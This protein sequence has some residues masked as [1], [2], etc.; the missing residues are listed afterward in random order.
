MKGKYSHSTN[1]FL[2]CLAAIA[3]LAGILPSAQA[4][5]QPHGNS[6]Q[7]SGYAGTDLLDR[8]PFNRVERSNFWTGGWNI[9][10]LRT[11]SVTVSYAEIH[12][13]FTS[14]DFRDTYQARSSWS[15]GAEAH[16]ITHLRKFSMSG[17]F[18]FDNFSGKEMCGQM[19]ARPGYY[20]FDV[21]EFTPGPKIMQTYAFSG[22]ITADIAPH[23]R[24]GGM[25]SYTGANYTKRK[26]LR[27]SNY[28][29]DMTVSPSVLYHSGDFSMGLSYIFGKN[30]ETIN[31]DELGISSASYYAFL[32]KGLMFGAYETWEGS[33]IHLSESGVNG[34][35]AR[36][37]R[38]GVAIQAGWRNFYGEASYVFGSGS[39]GEK[40]SIWF[41]FPSHSAR[42]TAGYSFGKKE[43]R[44]LVRLAVSWKGLEN[45]ENV[46]GQETVN[47]V[48]ITKVYGSNLI[49]E[50]SVVNI[51]PSYEWLSGKASIKAGADIRWQARLSSQMYP[52]LFSRDDMI[53]RVYASGSVSL[54]MFDLKAGLAFSYGN[55]LEKDRVVDDGIQ[56]GE[57]PYHLEDLYEMQNEY[58]T[59]PRLESALGLRYNFLKGLY[60]EISGGYARGFNIAVLDGKDRWSGNIR[61]GYTF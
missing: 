37:L 42:L 45:H 53:S 58:M 14:G 20:P 11:D 54:K 21:L 33:G 43:S 27:H 52:Y 25:I 1:S 36:E 56:T 29:L 15:A 39:A 31:A 8:G 59:A 2:A 9:N 28:L 57:L 26:D 18:S 24:I 38:H 12:G 19:S 6:L 40:Q 55:S 13:N 49:F 44:H 7:E 30:S 32:D 10:G 48:T 34:F 61:L 35:P 47:G 60:A 23:W 51:S 50:R 22:G 5:A 46:I 16:T 4:A 3:V 41:V 17:S